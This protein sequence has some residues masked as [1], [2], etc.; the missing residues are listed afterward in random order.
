MLEEQLEKFGLSEK[1]AKAYITLLVLGESSATEIAEKSGVNRS[2]AYV[3]L[4]ALQKKGLVSSSQAEKIQKFKAA[5]PEKLEQIAEE[6]LKQHQ[7]IH[8]TV[9]KILPNLKGVH[10]DQEF[11]PRVRIF[12]GKEGLKEAFEETLHTKEKT[13]RVA[14]SLTRL[15]KKLGLFIPNYIQRRI[16]AGIKMYGI[17][18]NDKLGRFLMTIGSGEF[19]KPLL[20]PKDKYHFEAD[21]AIFDDRVAFMT[22]E[23][24]GYAVSVESEKMAQI[25][26]TVFDLAYERAEQIVSKNS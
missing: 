20:I 21:L 26:K 17:H 23:G 25:M 13:M 6:K 4:E 9:K 1:E 12:E 22:S 16:K 18:P 10:K 2:S 3:V 11:R 24:R 5:P 15:S 14:S 19:D 8:D 7:E